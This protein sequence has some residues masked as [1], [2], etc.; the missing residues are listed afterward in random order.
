MAVPLT[1]VPAPTYPTPQESHSLG[2][3]SH[4]SHSPGPCSHV[5]SIVLGILLS[6]VSC[7]P[8]IPLPRGPV[9]AGSN[10]HRGP[11]PMGVPAHPCPCVCAVLL[12]VHAVCPAVHPRALTLHIHVRMSLLSSRTSVH[13]CAACPSVHAASGCRVSGASLRASSL[14]A[15]VT[16]ET[17]AHSHLYSHLR[18]PAT[19]SITPTDNVQVSGVALGQPGW[20][21]EHRGHAA[22]GSP[23]AMARVRGGAPPI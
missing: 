8:G 14:P 7:S 21:Q 12:Y 2:S 5:C 22:A 11:A 10:S 16:P 13:P 19:T 3:C 1:G 17:W 4:V 18:P 9:S 6:Q 15:P 23:G 20:G